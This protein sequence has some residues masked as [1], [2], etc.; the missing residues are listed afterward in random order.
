LSKDRVA[1]HVTKFY[2]HQAHHSG[3]TRAIELAA[4]AISVG[5]LPAAAAALA[6]SRLPWVS[7]DGAALLKAI[8]GRLGIPAPEVDVADGPRLWTASDVSTFAALYDR[9]AGQAQL[10]KGIFCAASRVP[11]LAKS[12]D[13][14][15]PGGQPDGGQYCSAA[16]TPWAGADQP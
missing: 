7:R 15:L 1:W 4:A 12:N 8:G 3:L 11:G 14:H 5:D 13:N 2:G 6:K 9:H 16:D 10:L